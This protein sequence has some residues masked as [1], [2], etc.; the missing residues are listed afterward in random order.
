MGIFDKILGQFIDIIEWLDDT[1][2]TLVY[3][4]ERQ[5]N[6]IKTGEIGRAHV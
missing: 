6:E 2:E 3:R 5:G 4:F 1:N